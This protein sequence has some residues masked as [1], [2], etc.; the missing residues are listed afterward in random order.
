MTNSSAPP[1]FN[2]FL[3]IIFC[4]TIAQSGAKVG[5]ESAPNP[6]HDGK[7]SNY[8]EL[9]VSLGAEKLIYQQGENIR[10]E[11]A[12]TNTGNK[13]IYLYAHLTLGRL[14][15]LEFHF[16]DKYGKEIHPVF[17]SNSQIPPPYEPSQFARLEPNHFLGIHLELP[18]ESWTLDWPGKYTIVAEC[19]SPVSEEFAPKLDIWPSEKGSI[20]SEPINITIVRPL[21]Q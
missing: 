19:H 12:V 6:K 20:Y 14:S 15:S 16:F 2:V 21:P 7:T 4:L 13:P 18:V 5:F 8:G 1:A 17:F 10:L 3:L 9:T 11:V